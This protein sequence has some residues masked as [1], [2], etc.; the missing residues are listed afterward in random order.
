MK[1]QKHITD[2]LLRQR[3]F[4]QLLGKEYWCYGKGTFNEELMKEHGFVEV[5][6]VGQANICLECKLII[7]SY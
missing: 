3:D 2:N 1:T 7:T 6:D 4:D 5:Y